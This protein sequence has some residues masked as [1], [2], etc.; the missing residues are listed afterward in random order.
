MEVSQLHS[1]N[2]AIFLIGVSMAWTAGPVTQN[3]NSR[4][5]WNVSGPSLNTFDTVEVGIVAGSTPITIVEHL[6]R[7]GPVHSIT[8]DTRAAGAASYVIRGGLV[9]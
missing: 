3:G 1:P 2:K 6:V 7:P 8:V 5:T 9:P 4:F